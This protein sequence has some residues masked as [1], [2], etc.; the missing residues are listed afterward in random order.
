MQIYT[1]ILDEAV[2]LARKEDIERRL[3]TALDTDQN[4]DVLKKLRG[5]MK[6]VKHNLV[7]IR[8]Q[9]GEQRS[10]LKGGKLPAGII[11]QFFLASHSPEEHNVGEYKVDK[12]LSNK[13]VRVY[14]NPSSKWAVVVHR[15]SAD[16]K[17]AFYDG[18][19][20]FGI[21]DNK[22]FKISAK[23]QKEAEKKYDPKRMTVLGS[24]LGGTLAETSAGKDV[25]E[26]ITAGKPVTPLQLLQNKGTR[27][28]QFDVRTDTDVISVLKPLQKEN[29]N[30]ITFES[31][32]PL[33]PLKSHFGAEVFGEKYFKEDEM[34]GRGPPQDIQRMKV[35]QLKDAIKFERKQ[36]KYK[37]ADWK[38]SKM[39]KHDLQKMYAR[40]IS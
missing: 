9:I 17:D 19:L 13:F 15:G 22:R 26:I 18:Q 33:N 3:Q 6:E 4:K 25:H 16:L 2:N 27:P 39:K 11:K 38:V 14:Y 8:K 29:K 20:L 40:I 32:T 7:K 10:Q 1:T 5:E 31:K 12:E 35:A 21:T 23:V 28:N 37:A 30:D 36:R 24:S 34:V